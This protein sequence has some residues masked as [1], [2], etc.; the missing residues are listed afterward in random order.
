MKRGTPAFTLVELL[1]SSAILVA[2]LA[3]VYVSFEAG[4]FGYRD[5]MEAL[6][7]SETAGLTLWQMN[8]ELRNALAFAKD[9]T[10]FEGKRREISFLAIVPAADS[11]TLARLSYLLEGGKIYRKIYRGKESLNRDASVQ[12]QEICSGVEELRFEYGY[13]GPAPGEL[14]WKDY[15]DDPGVLPVAV[16]ITLAVQAKTRRIFERVVFCPAS[17][18]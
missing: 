2:V 14:L 15:W 16:R 5:V 10:C 9:Q 8:T 11:E 6:R 3:A 17:Q 12:P 18:R 1:V 7:Q 13:P 4:L